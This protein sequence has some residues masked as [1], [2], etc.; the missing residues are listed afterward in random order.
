MGVTQGVDKFGVAHIHA[1]RGHIILV[2]HGIQ[3]GCG[4]VY[5]GGKR[6][7]RWRFVAGYVLQDGQG[8]V[9]IAIAGTPQNVVGVSECGLVGQAQSGGQSQ[10]GQRR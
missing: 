9:F 7:G 6:G 8:F 3:A 2:E 5:G 4:I 1:G 10:F